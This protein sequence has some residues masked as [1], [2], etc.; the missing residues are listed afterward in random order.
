MITHPTVGDYISNTCQRCKRP[1]RSRLEL[2][3]VKMARTRLV[4]RDVMVDVC[5]ECGHMISFAPESIQQLR[6]AGCPK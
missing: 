3:S 1:V 4:V 2:R 5:P 6:E